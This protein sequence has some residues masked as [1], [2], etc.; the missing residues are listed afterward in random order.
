MHRLKQL[1]STCIAC[2]TLLIPGAFSQLAYAISA[3][4]CHYEQGFLD[5]SNNVQTVTG[6]QELQMYVYEPN[7]SDS[8]YDG[9]DKVTVSIDSSK[10]TL[11]AGRGNGATVTQSG[12][13]ISY[14]YN[15]GSGTYIKTT[16]NNGQVIYFTV[17]PIGN[18]SIGATTFTV[19]GSNVWNGYA[20][21]QNVACVS[22]SPTYSVAYNYVNP[23]PNAPTL[24][25][26]AGNQ[27]NSLQWNSVSGATSYTLYQAGTAIYTGTA[28]TYTHTGLNN[29]TSYSYTVKA[30]NSAGYSAASNSITLTPPLPPNAPTLSGTAA[31]RQINLS[32]TQ[33]SGATQYS[34]TR[35]GTQIYQG[36]ATSYADT[37]LTNGI[38]HKYVVYASNVSGSGANSNALSL[39]A[40]SAAS[41]VTDR[42]IQL[43]SMGLAG[44]I[45]VQLI[46]PFRWRGND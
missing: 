29:G 1:I 11:S 28:T 16:Q 15:L 5:S 41:T 17:T 24:S 12:N 6:Q 10:F 22:D 35:D 46:K 25:G 45:S 36:T 14:S 8:N 19:N 26:T 20:S 4:S 34:L 33:P 40:M 32:W 2:A 30:Q 43:V 3:G 44:Y 27:Q 7:S 18:A 9:V 31:D 13:T 23:V 37:G 39:A 42:D 38:A 21:E